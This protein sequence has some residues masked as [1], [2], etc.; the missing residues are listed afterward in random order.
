LAFMYKESRPLPRRPQIAARGL[1]SSRQSSPPT[2][3]SFAATAAGLAV[4]MAGLA[5]EGGLG[6]GR[7]G[8]P[9]GFAGA[10]LGARPMA[11][12]RAAPLAGVVVEVSPAACNWRWCM[13]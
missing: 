3:E 9:T 4:M 2:P 7:W 8:L 12:A 1:P 5:A 10:E 11:A 13:G 6:G